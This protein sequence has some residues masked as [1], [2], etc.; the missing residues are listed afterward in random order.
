MTLTALEVV[1]DARVKSEHATLNGKKYHYLLGAPSKPFTETI[2]LIHGWPDLSVGW[3]N[4]I[5]MLLD[6]GYRVVVPDMM[7]YGGTE[8]PQVSPGSPDG[9]AEN[10]KFYSFKRVADDVAE[11]ARQL[12]CSRIILGGHDWGAIIVYR[13]ALWHPE[14]ISSLFAVC[15]PYRAPSSQ[16]IDFE[17]AVKT[18]LPNFGY[19][20]HLGS[21][22]VEEHI[23]TKEQ[24]T[25]FLNAVYGGRGD[26]GEVGFDTRSGPIYENLPKLQQSRLIKPEILDFYAQQYE[27]AGIHGGLNWYRTR[28]VNFE[29]ELELVK[30]V[31]VLLLTS[32]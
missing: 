17:K 3:R 19:Q 8:V 31:I 22:E 14:L 25:Q 26:N 20:L 29:Q 23:K 13:I 10:I 24:V 32:N 30:Y 28:D 27:K 7:G 12:H 15:A 16:N 9:S 1:G 18:V 6:M 21:G 11:L 5:P 4:Q 2:F